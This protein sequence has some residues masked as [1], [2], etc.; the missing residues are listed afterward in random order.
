[1]TFKRTP[2]GLSA[3]HKFVNA[4]LVIFTE[5]GK[6][7]LKKSEVLSGKHNKESF[8]AV[9]WNV[10]YSIYMPDKKTYFI[11][12]GSKS[13][14]DEIAKDIINEDL[15]TVHVAMD[16]DYANFMKNLLNH[17]GIL[18]TYGYSWEN[19]VFNKETIISIVY[20]LKPLNPTDVELK[21]KISQD[22]KL[23]LDKYYRNIKR[24]VS[25]D[26][27]LNKYD[28]CLI[29]KKGEALIKVSGKY[30]KP[31]LNKNKILKIIAELKQ[32]R[33]NRIN[34]DK[35]M[36]I[37]PKEDCY[38]KLFA[39]FCYRT[40]IYIINKYSSKFSPSK[41]NV[42]VLAIHYMQNNYNHAVYADIKNHY[43]QNLN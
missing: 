25:L 18:Y 39:S 8:D 7:S 30:K 21:T 35:K 40:V 26:V 16:R 42:F 3:Y 28:K 32:D 1:M 27:L 22:I 41:E 38:G 6:S 13:T 20:Q 17:K 33:K 9:F 24:V 12:I 10:I 29:P 5:G 34:A 23:L 37:R 19:D 11:P 15:K 4:E 36:N 14:L 43:D 2:S 31:S